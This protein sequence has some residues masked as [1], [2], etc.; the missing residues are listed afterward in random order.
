M[1]LYQPLRRGQIRL[2]RT[3]KYDAVSNEISFG[4]DRHALTEA[5]PYVAISYTW[6]DPIGHEISADAVLRL[7]GFETIAT[8]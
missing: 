3:R 7:D 8:I 2:L 1:G 4:L 5:P 6:Q